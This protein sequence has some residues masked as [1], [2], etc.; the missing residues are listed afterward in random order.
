MAAGTPVL[1]TDVGGLPEAVRDLSTDLIMPDSGVR[2]LAGYMV[3]ALKGALKLPDSAACQAYVRER[4]DWP[5]IARHVRDVYE[6][7][8]S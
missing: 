5:V 8:I 1:V 3:D 6:E 2:T 4:F 7:V